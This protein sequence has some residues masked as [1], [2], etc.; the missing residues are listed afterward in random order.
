MEIFAKI[1]QQSRQVIITGSDND[2]VK[3]NATV[4][5]I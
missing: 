5:K 3:F 2:T 1:V 4:L